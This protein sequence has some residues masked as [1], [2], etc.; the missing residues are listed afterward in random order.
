MKVI[1]VR[2]RTFYK[3]KGGRLELFTFSREAG[4]KN[5]ILVAWE[6]SLNGVEAVAFVNGL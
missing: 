4:R 2:L 6:A 5:A 1:V 3:V